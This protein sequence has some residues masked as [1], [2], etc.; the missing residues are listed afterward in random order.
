MLLFWK[1][2]I[3]S[4]QGGEQGAREKG[5]AQLGGIPFAMQWPH[6]MGWHGVGNSEVSWK[7]ER[8]PQPQIA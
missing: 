1:V 7:T 5:E 4:L 2:E 3:A 8:R 6:G